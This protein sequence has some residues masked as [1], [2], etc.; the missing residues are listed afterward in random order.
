MQ[1]SAVQSCL[2]ICERTCHRQPWL[3]PITITMSGPASAASR[4]AIES[5]VITTR[6]QASIICAT[7]A[8]RICD[9]WVSRERYCTLSLPRLVQADACRHRSCCSRLRCLRGN[10][11]T[12]IVQLTP[13]G[14]K[15]TRSSIPAGCVWRSSRLG[16]I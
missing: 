5:K 12:V 9:E 10:L 14:W 15:R 1:C 2:L 8:S 7:C 11:E 6:R 16:R 3:V 13:L 4:S